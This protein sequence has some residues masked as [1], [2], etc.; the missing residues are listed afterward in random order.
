[1]RSAGAKQPE[2]VGHEISTAAETPPKPSFLPA[3]TAVAG[4]GDHSEGASEAGVDRV[5]QLGLDPS[6]AASSKR[7]AEQSLS[8]DL[9][10]TWAPN[11]FRRSRV[12]RR[13][14]TAEW[15]PLLVNIG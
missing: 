12:K 3:L 14:V 5:P 6:P 15:N 8:S 2:S 13:G 1:L 10:S 7:P 4:G 9:D 11:P